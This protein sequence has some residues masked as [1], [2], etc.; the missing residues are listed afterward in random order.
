MLLFF[1]HINKKWL[2]LKTT[3]RSYSWTTL[4][5]QQRENGKVRQT[6]SIEMMVRRFATRPGPSSQSDITPWLQW[7]SPTQLFRINV[8]GNLY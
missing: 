2:N 4:T 3:A 5:V 6:S 1:R 7:Y 8:S